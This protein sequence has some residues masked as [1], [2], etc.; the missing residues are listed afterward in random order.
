M[1]FIEEVD[2]L[3]FG[4]IVEGEDV[5]TLI[6]L[7]RSH[8]KGLINAEEMVGEIDSFKSEFYQKLLRRQ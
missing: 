6:N 5:L 3:I 7:L 2:W 8:L 1:N 4:G